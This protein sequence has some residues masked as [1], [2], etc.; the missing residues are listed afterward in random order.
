MKKRT[1]PAV[2]SPDVVVT[3]EIAGYPFLSLFFIYMRLPLP[4][5]TYSEWDAEKKPRHFCEVRV[6]FLSTDGKVHVHFWKR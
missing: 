2:F 4:S 3:A 6:L 1:A 5:F